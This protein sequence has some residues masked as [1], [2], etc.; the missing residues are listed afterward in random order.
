SD[1]VEI[2]FTNEDGEVAEF[3]EPVAL[4]L[5]ISGDASVEGDFLAVA[6]VE[7]DGLVIYGGTVEGGVI[8]VKRTS[9]SAYTVVENRVDFD[10]TASVNAWAGHQIRSIAAKGIVDGRGDGVFD[11]NAN[12]TRAEFAK[13]LARALGI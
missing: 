10:D 2:T 12:V 7:E 6:K 4:E 5:T 9:F 1:V 13:M 3:D 8:R 11:P